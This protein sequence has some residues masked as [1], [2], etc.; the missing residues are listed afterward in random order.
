MARGA[1]VQRSVPV[2]PDEVGGA[3][4]RPRLAVG[5]DEQH[6]SR[7]EPVHGL[8][9]RRRGD[10]LQVGVDAGQVGRAAALQS[11]VGSRPAVPVGSR[12]DAADRSHAEGGRAGLEDRP[13][14]EGFGTHVIVIIRSSGAK[15]CGPTSTVIF[16]TVGSPYCGRTDAGGKRGWTGPQRRR[17]GPIEQHSSSVRADGFVVERQSGRT[18]PLSSVSP[19]AGHRCRGRCP[20]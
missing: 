8:R 18:A 3:A 20:P 7:A 14:V 16:K 9:D 1:E 12:G 11:V 19:G 6:R 10:R 2:P 5:R 4:R 17:P 15:D 13:P